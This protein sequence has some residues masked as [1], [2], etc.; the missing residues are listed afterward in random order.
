MSEIVDTRYTSFKNPENGNKIEFWSFEKENHEINR[1]MEIHLHSGTYVNITEEDM[2]KED[3]FEE[4]EKLK[5]SDEWVK[6]E[7]A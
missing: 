1:Q 2:D 5:S 6:Q 3:Y 7:E 4:I